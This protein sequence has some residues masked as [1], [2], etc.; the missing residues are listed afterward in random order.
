MV[1]NGFGIKSANDC[2][3]RD[4]KQVRI[5]AKVEGN[6]QG[7]VHNEAEAEILNGLIQVGQA[8]NLDFKG[9]WET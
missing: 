1:L 5:Y 9:R 3:H 8:K 6:E 4:P 2:P 7:D